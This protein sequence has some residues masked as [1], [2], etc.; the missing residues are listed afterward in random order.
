MFWDDGRNL[1]LAM[2]GLSNT[3]DKGR[4]IKRKEDECFPQSCSRGLMSTHFSG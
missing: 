4:K 3:V 1:A 2:V